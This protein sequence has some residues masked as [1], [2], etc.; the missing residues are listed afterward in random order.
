MQDLKIAME[1][2]PFV[3][4]ILVCFFV[5]IVIAFIIGMWSY[6][7]KTTEQRLLDSYLDIYTECTTQGYNH[8]MCQKIALGGMKR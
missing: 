8:D 1:D 2:Q 5:G 6:S 4:W 7:P 3:F